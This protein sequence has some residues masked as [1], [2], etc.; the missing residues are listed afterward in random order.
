MAGF[1]KLKLTQLKHQVLKIVLT[2]L[3]VCLT[4]FSNNIFSSN[5]IV[6]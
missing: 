2:N 6:Q 1:L 3:R 5:H 4:I